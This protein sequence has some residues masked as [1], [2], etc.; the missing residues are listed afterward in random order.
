MSGPAGLA[1]SLE[2][3]TNRG[4]A[5]RPVHPAADNG[6]AAGT[7]AGQEDLQYRRKLLEVGVGGEFIYE[8][9]QQVE[10]PL[11]VRLLKLWRERG[12]FSKFSTKALQADPSEESG[13][14]QA[15]D[16]EVD[17]HIDEQ[18]GTEDEEAGETYQQD[19]AQT[20]K[21]RG[22]TKAQEE[23]ALSGQNMT[24]QEMI[25]LKEGM[26]QQLT[27]A[28]HAIYFSN[29]LVSL[30]ISSAKPPPTLASSVAAGAGSLPGSRAGSPD[31]PAA[32]AS[33]AGAGGTQA[34]G[35]EQGWG[36]DPHIM[37]L[38][39]IA[40]SEDPAEANEQDFDERYPPSK[41]NP[42]KTPY[43][44]A[45][46]RANALAA[47]RD[48]L[49]DA[50]DILRN[51]ALQIR[52]AIGALDV[53]DDEEV[54]MEEDAPAPSTAPSDAG[55]LRLAAAERI[56]QEGL[57][58]IKASG[59]V[60]SLQPGRPTEDALR[61][62]P[63]LLL[64]G[65]PNP[66]RKE[67]ARDAWI[68]WGIPECELPSLEHIERRSSLYRSARQLTNPPRTPTARPSYRWRTTAH[69]ASADDLDVDPAEVPEDPAQIPESI[70]ARAIVVPGRPK[71]R[72]RVCFRVQE[73]Q[74][75]ETAE[76]IYTSDER[77]GTDAQTTDS[78]E[79]IDSVLQSAADEV[80]DLELFDGVSLST[81]VDTEHR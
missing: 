25:Q 50:I 26:L 73:E 30:L 16:K 10:S 20:A 64:Q 33:S 32:P 5:S 57:R 48:G 13:Q 58:R 17:F 54:A 2:P 74:A 49:Q 60:W 3:P 53:H 67:A 35:E 14:K 37:G 75:G 47:K 9:E 76:R 56:R 65:L 6:D 55:H 15:A 51:G 62:R 12:D 39:K 7:H 66:N 42:L 40:L 27:A 8:N 44:L 79:T 18:D 36:V 80:A 71:K 11:S 19:A 43:E 1:L 22:K 24:V 52:Q 38:T 77:T 23:R 68:G 29:M 28:Q 61:E 4:A 31:R 46:E 34:P 41:V 70:I 63:G 72:L 21:A 81:W 59:S 78:E 45:R 69:F